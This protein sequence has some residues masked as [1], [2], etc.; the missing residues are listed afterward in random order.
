MLSKRKERMIQL[1][2][3]IIVLIILYALKN[4]NYFVRVSTFVFSVFLFYFADR[5]F[6]LRFKK[7]HYIAFLLVSTA[8]ILLSPLYF[9]SPN[10]DKILHIASPILIGFLVYY[11]ADRAKISFPIKLLIT[12]SV[13]VSS[14]ALFEII[15]YIIDQFFDFK[16]QGVFL[17]DISGVAKL[18]IIMDRNDDTMI[19]LILGTIGS[20][21]FIGYKSIEYKIQSLK[22]K[23]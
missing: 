4:T 12:F 15:E 19:D 3:G 22:K 5:F 17:R 20:A 23:K 16:L 8:G 10:Y 13:V 21:I 11:L 7:S 2:V 6:N 18:N 1:T 14:L 9:I